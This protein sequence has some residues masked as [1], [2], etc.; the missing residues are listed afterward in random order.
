[1]LLR[2]HSRKNSPHLS[3]DLPDCMLSAWA[4]CFLSILRTS[5]LGAGPQQL[6]PVKEAPSCSSG[7]D[8]A[9]GPPDLVC[10]ECQSSILLRLS[11][12]HPTA[13][14]ASTLPGPQSAPNH[15]GYQGRPSSG[16]QT[17]RTGRGRWRASW[18]LVPPPPLAPLHTGCPWSEPCAHTLWGAGQ[19]A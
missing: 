10:Q 12:H 5:C 16:H 18:P 19:H 4:L 14:H 17:P 2:P 3:T 7:C 15:C 9:Q 6:K 1:M 13:P 8:Q 11:P